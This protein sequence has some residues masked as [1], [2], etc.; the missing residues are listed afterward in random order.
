MAEKASSTEVGKYGEDLA[1][2]ALCA[3][4]YEIVE[5]NW[6]CQIGEIDVVARQDG[7]WVFVEVKTR[8]GTGHGTPEEGVTDVKR[9]RVLRVGLAYLAEHELED[10]AW[11]VDVVAI[12]LGKTGKVRRL[13]IYRDAVWAQDE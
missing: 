2:Q 7:E 1:V 8:Q 4:G 9:S 3:H 10:V 6:R 5:Q 11:R 12:E 13:A